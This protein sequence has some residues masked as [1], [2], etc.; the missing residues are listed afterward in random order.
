[1]AGTTSRTTLLIPKAFSAQLNPYSGY[2]N[3]KSPYASKNLKALFRTQENQNYL[4]ETLFRLLTNEEYVRWQLDQAEVSDV[5]MTAHQQPNE[6]RR[7]VA[8][9]MKRK[10]FLQ[11]NIEDLVEMTELPYK[12]DIVLINPIQQLHVLNKDFLVKTAR[13]IIHCPDM[14]APRYFATNPET[15][16]DESQIEYDFTSEAYADG[17]WHPE[18]LFTN[19][20]RNRD[21]PYWIPRE[22]NI[23]ADDDSVGVGHRYYNK[24]Y[25]KTQ[26]TRSQFPRWQ[27]S[28]EDRP[29]ERCTEES[30]REGGIS[31]RFVQ[32]NSGYNMAALVSKST[33]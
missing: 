13:D 18:H 22:V 8:A 27:Y 5:K 2:L 25:S 32:R 30:L 3:P 15:G 23:Y 12:E 11:D 21:N 26:R 9:F 14:L 33:Y 1:M 10:K 28:M 4:F 19:S 7:L 6:A 31:D 20:N 29:Y 24:Q 16:A 17:T